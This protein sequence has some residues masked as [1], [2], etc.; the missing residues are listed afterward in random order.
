MARLG[1]KVCESSSLNMILKGLQAPSVH[2]ATFAILV[3]LQSGALYGECPMMTLLVE[4]K[5][6]CV[7]VWVPLYCLTGIRGPEQVHFLTS[8]KYKY[9]HQVRF[10]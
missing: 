4:R 5:L 3:G 10:P 7:R 9:R 2:F 6:A 8:Y 1:R